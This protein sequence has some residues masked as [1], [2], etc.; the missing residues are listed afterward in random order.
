M[1]V[2]RVLSSFAPLP[3]TANDKAAW[4][5]RPITQQDTRKHPKSPA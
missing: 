5:G 1:R 4:R 3:E 2:L